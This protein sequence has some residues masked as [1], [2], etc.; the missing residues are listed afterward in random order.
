MRHV[1]QRQSSAGTE[2]LHVDCV[3]KQGGGDG[4]AHDVA[5][6]ISLVGQDLAGNESGHVT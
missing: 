5:C 2:Q 3:G 4:V 1:T 6:D